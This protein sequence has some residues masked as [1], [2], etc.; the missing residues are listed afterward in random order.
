L[1]WVRAQG[2][3][4]HTPAVQLSIRMLIPPGSALLAENAGAPW[5]G[6]LDAANFSYTWTHPDERMDRLQRR[7]AYLA[8]ETGD[9]DPY[10]AFALVEAAAYTL[11]AIAPPPPLPAP[12]GAVAPPRLSEHWFC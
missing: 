10:T 5:L 1:D 3:V 2:L 11:A 7:I 12:A 4:A 8:E 9:A 6:A